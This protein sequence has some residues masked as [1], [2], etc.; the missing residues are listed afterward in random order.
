MCQDCLKVRVQI[1]EEVLVE[2]QNTKDPSQILGR[3]RTNRLTFFP[4]KIEE[5][6]GKTVKVRI[7]EI[8]AFSLTGVAVEILD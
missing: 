4:G 2:V 7:D 3:T 8:R 5:L 1:I 6:K